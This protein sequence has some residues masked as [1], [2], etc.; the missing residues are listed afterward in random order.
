[1][2]LQTKVK[3]LW[4]A[5]TAIF[6]VIALILAFLAMISYHIPP[7]KIFRDGV[8]EAILTLVAAMSEW[9]YEVVA[10][11]YRKRK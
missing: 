10:E 9:R 8:G 4:W 7:K 5:I 2:N 6:A 3:I 1:M 11:F